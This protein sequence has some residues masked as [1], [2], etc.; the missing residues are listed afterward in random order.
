MSLPLKQYQRQTLA[1]MRDM[2]DAS[3][4]PRG[5]NGLFWEERAFGDGGTYYFSPQLGEMRLEAP[6]LMHGGLLCDEARPPCHP[7]R[8][9]LGGPVARGTAPLAA[10]PRPS[11]NKVRQ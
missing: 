10:L 1:W 8:L 7:S 4:L 3:L 6:P 2:E 11:R 9:P 5:I